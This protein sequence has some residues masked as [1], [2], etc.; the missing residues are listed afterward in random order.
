MRCG[1]RSG[2][3]TLAR[4]AGTGLSTRA[5]VTIRWF[6]CPFAA[7][8]AALPEGRI[9][10]VGCGHG[11]L[12]LR[13]AATPG[14]EIV[15]I[16]PDGSKLAVARQAAA[17]SPRLISPLT[18]DEMAP[19]HL[20]DEMIDAA[21]LND[22]LYLM[23]PERQRRLLRDLVDRLRPGGRLVIKTNARS[24]RWKLALAT[25]EEWLATGA[26][27]ITRSDGEGLHLCP[28]DEIAG[29]LQERGLR[30]EGRRIDRWYPWPHYLLVAVKG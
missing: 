25:V 21:V 7:V 20:P 18:I 4:Y 13:L 12:S 14:R 24:P 30:T 26:L 11:L 8:E 27:G 28:P 5:H 23:T 10:D 15:A 1:L 16:D 19:G 9:L 2:R 3:E 29:W 17:G 22:V 6:S